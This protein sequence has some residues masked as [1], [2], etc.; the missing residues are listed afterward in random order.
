MHKEYVD[1]IDYCNKFDRV[2]PWPDYWLKMYDLLPKKFENT[3]IQYAPSP[4]ILVG[5]DT[6]SKYKKK[7]LNEQI[8]WAQDT[9]VFILVDKFLRELNEENWFHEYV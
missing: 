7:R 2:C 9:G 5:W 6:Q 3:K 4:L 8:K 1:L